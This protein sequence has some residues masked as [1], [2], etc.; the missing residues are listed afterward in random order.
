MKKDN[1]MIN[2]RSWPDIHWLPQRM[3][4]YFHGKHTHPFTAPR[5]DEN[6]IYFRD[7]RPWPFGPPQI[8]K[9][10][11]Y[12]RDK[13]SCHLVS[14]RSMKI[15]NE[16][17]F[18]DKK[19]VGRAFTLVSQTLFILLQLIFL[20]LS[21]KNACAID[22]ESKVIRRHLS[23]GMTVL[24]MERH[25][26]PVCSL[27]IRFKA[28][29]VDEPSGESGTAHFLEHLLFKGTKSIGTTDYM[30]ES[31][32]LEKIEKAGKYLDWE[33]QKGDKMD[34][35]R[36]EHLSKELA[37]L[38]S[39]HK[40]YVIK[41]EMDLIYSQNGEKGFNA[42]TGMD[43]TT[44]TVSLP[45][46]RIELWARIE[47]DRMMNPVFREFYSERDVVLEERRQSY[48]SNPFRKLLEQFLATAFLV[49]PYRNP[50]IG[51][52]SEIEMLDPDKV[53]EFFRRHYAPSNVIVAAVGDIDPDRFMQLMERYFG[54][55]PPQPPVPPVITKEPLQ[56]GERRI[57]VLFDAEPQLLIGFLK[58]TVPDRADY[59]FDIIS[60][61]L[62][63][64]RTSRLYKRMVID[65]KLAVS[66]NT[67]NGVPGGRYPN[68]FM[69]SA[70][71]LYPNTT[72]DIE[73]VIYEELE[74][75]KDEPVSDWELGKIKN[76]IQVEIISGLASNP[77]MAD[78]LSYFEAISGDWRYLSTYLDIISTITTGEIQD[79]ARKYFRKSQRTV[80]TLVKPEDG[81]I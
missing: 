26:T 69:I 18:R 73:R 50:I 42:S 20:L 8:M 81:E 25:E 32:I 11:G 35:N 22:L 28:G 52:E 70:T 40:K 49:H 14:P 47:S 64:G 56:R 43:L 17:Y 39:E 51:W 9:I 21:Y 36:V 3:K 61:I 48:D 41:D 66:V 54:R 19:K 31:I 63:D 65:E 4:I 44:Y 60:S 38:Q 33:R 67:M 1:F 7:K 2:K 53:M 37:A 75:L 10:E 58:P 78:K 16:V 45:S 80:A 5:G 79:A 46:N 30:K 24:I 72:E 77:G 55:I 74:R 71:P 62:T 12:F 27:Y 76:Q 57:E 15:N 68:I 13:R 34:P 23:N 6:R 29:A 59:I